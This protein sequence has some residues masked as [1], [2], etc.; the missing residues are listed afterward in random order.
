MAI[1]VDKKPVPIYTTSCV[2]E[3]KPWAVSSA[4]EHLPYTQRV[5]GSKPVPPT[6]HQLDLA[7]S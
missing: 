7:G 5:T 6:I 1:P 3:L 4:V 2:G